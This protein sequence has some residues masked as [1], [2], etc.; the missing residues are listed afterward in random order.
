MVKKLPEKSAK[1]PVRQSH[2]TRIINTRLSTPPKILLDMLKDHSS[3]EKSLPAVIDMERIK[4]VSQKTART[5]S[6]QIVKSENIV[7]QLSDARPHRH[8]QK[9][10]YATP[11]EEM[12][13]SEHLPKNVSN[14]TLEE[15]AACPS[16]QSRKLGASQD[17]KNEKVHASRKTLDNTSLKTRHSSRIRIPNSR[18]SY[19][20]PG[21]L[22]QASGNRK[23]K[24]SMK[25]NDDRKTNTLLMPEEEKVVAHSPKIA[26]NKSNMT[27]KPRH[28]ERQRIPSKRLSFPDVCSVIQTQKKSTKARPKV[29]QTYVK[30]QK[31]KNFNKKQASILKNRLSV[32]ATPA[33]LSMSSITSNRQVHSSLEVPSILYPYRPAR[34]Q[35]LCVEPSSSMTKDYVSKKDIEELLTEINKALACVTDE[36]YSELREKIAHHLNSLYRENC[37]FRQALHQLRSELESMSNNSTI[38]RYNLLI[39]QNGELREQKVL[40]DIK[41]EAQME[42]VRKLL[43]KIRTLEV[44]NKDLENFRNRLIEQKKQQHLNGK[45]KNSHTDFINDLSKTETQDPMDAELDSLILNEI[46]GKIVKSNDNEVGWGNDSW[47][48]HC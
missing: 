43:E 20:L 48:L 4:N 5:S 28:S 27:I 15:T 41:C 47:M 7:T 19:L 25:R 13:E 1:Q 36:D 32:K 22:E 35:A 18:F 11:F 26:C 9:K 10:R 44:R 23:G 8:I 45:R 31:Y 16:N 39:K 46:D 12:I 40:A 42:E 21:F 38:N 3:S 2:R 6:K 14:E 24:D 17:S 34:C 33:N 37:R 30:V 29:E